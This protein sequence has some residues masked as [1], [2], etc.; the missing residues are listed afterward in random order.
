[1]KIEPSLN[2]AISLHANPGVYALLV[3]S[4]L[5][6]A[7]G[8]P[9][10]WEIVLD[11]IGKLAALEQQEPLPDPESWYRQRFGEPASYDT[12]LERLTST[13]AERMAL[14]RSYFEP[15][16]EEREGELK[17]PTSAHRAVATLTRSGYFKLI[18]TT[19]FDRLMERA[20]EDEGIVPDV[21]SSDDALKGSIPYAH[22]RC[23]LVKLHGDYRDTRLKNTPEELAEYSQ[24]VNEFLDRVFDEFGLVICG[25]SGAWD[26]ALRDAIL[27]CPTRRFTTFWLARGEL[28]DE[29]RSIVHHRRAQVVSVESADQFFTQLWEKVESLAELAYPHPLSKSVAVAT[30]KRYLPEARH[31]IRLRD[32]VHEETERVFLEA[33]SDQFDTQTRQVPTIDTFRRRMKQY[34]ATVEQLQSI[35][36]ALA[37][38]DTG[39]NAHLLTDIIQRLCSSSQQQGHTFLLDLQF[40]PALLVTYASGI[41]ALAAGRFK[42]LA[43]ILSGPYYRESSHEEKK[44]AVTR[45]HLWSVFKH[46]GKWIPRPEADREHTPASN[47]LCDFLYEAV[48]D[49]IPGKQEY[50]ETFDIFEYVLAL[51]Y[52][53]LVD[54]TWSPVGAYGWR[55]RYGTSRSPIAEFVAEGYAQEASW[56][57]LKEGFFAGSIV[58]C[59]E[60]IEAHKAWVQ[61]VAARW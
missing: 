59:K 42:N 44:P 7:A 1:M 13:P 34:E 61:Q 54:F 58:R 16:E 25:W 28:T 35:T 24:E 23:Q 4:G 21:I 2:L 60:I 56:G 26:V 10:G 50:I 32:L 29:A 47:Y 20:L 31:R 33:A 9:T 52:M 5:S 6:R 51:T 3:G 40:Y 53:D 43:A 30:V 19:N 49:Y 38:Y 18:L 37:F 41:S 22:S 8:V 17:R 57:L 15:N 45:L 12:L 55:Y 14:L 48:H 27:R 46:T 11:L 39:E 36:A